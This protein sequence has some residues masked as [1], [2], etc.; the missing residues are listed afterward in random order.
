MA[1]M[2]PH[3]DSLT[4]AP[5]GHAFAEGVD[6]P[7]DFVTWDT[8]I[9]NAGPQPFFNKEV[10]VTNATRLHFHADLSRAGFRNFTLDEFE[11][12]A[13]SWDLRYTHLFHTFLENV[14]HE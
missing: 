9:L 3:A 2:P 5:C 7:R 6:P 14:F 13:S 10:A 11:N 4:W 1:A 12:S 8:R